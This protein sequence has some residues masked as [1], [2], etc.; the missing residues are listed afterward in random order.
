MKGCANFWKDIRGKKLPKCNRKK[1]LQDK[2]N[3][4]LSSHR[5]FDPIPRQKFIKQAK[6]LVN[7]RWSG[8][9]KTL[10][11]YHLT[12]SSH[13][14]KGNGKNFS[15]RHD[16]YI[17]IQYQIPSLITILLSHLEGMKRLFGSGALEIGC[18]APSQAN[19]ST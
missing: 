9:S 19:Q 2:P 8:T 3:T 14:R 16:V 4:A 12:S 13:K 1:A 17:M 7:N 5:V 10:I 6:E 18:L 11:C 15:Q